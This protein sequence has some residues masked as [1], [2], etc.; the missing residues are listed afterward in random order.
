MTQQHPKHATPDHPIHELIAH[1][2]S[3]YAYAPRPVPEADLETCL[4]AARWAPSSYNDQPWTFLLARRQ[5]EAEFETMLSCLLPGNQAWAKDAGALLLTV[6]RRRFAHNGNPNKAA[7]HDIGL[8][9][10]MLVVQATEL[11]LHVHQMIGL[12]AEKA[13]QTY[14]VPEGHDVLTAIAI[15]YADT[16]GERTDDLAARD[17]KARSRRALAESVFG[18]RWGE[19]HAL[20]TSR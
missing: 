8:A 16:S 7:E 14:G 6:V 19:P 2:W 4:E 13:R 1:R 11:G 12:D 18:G 5:D 15:G 9:V 10:G 20:F 17:A 3:P